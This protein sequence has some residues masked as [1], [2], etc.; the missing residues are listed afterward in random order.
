M[1]VSPPLGPAGT[2]A[3]MDEREKYWGPAVTRFLAAIGKP[4]PE[5]MTAEQEAAF[6]RAQDEADAALERRLGLGHP[7]AA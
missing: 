3:G 5:P 2:I 4:L 6:E 7:A 1:T